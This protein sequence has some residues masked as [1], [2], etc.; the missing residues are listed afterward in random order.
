MNLKHSIPKVILEKYK[1]TEIEYSAPFNVKKSKFIDGFIIVDHNYIYTFIDNKLYKKYSLL[2]LKK[3]YTVPTFGG[4]QMLAMYKNGK[5][6][7]MLSYTKEYVSLLGSIALGIDMYV[8]ENFFAKSNQNETHCPKCHLP[9][10]NGSTTCVFCEKKIGIIRQLLK[11]IYPYRF[12]IIFQYLLLLIPIIISLFNPWIY[13]KLV[14]D[15]IYAKNYNSSFLFL[16]ISL[17]CLY[18]VSVLINIIKGRIEPVVS[19]GIVNDIRISLY[20]KVQKLSLNS[21]NSKTTG[22]LINRLSNDTSVIQSFLT[23][24]LPYIIING[25]TILFSVIIMAIMEPIFTLAIIL[26]MPLVFLIR[27]LIYVKIGSKYS[28]VWRYNEKANDTLHDIINGIKVVKTFSKEEKEINRFKKCNEDIKIITY[29]T[30]KFWY[31]LMPITWLTFS[32]VD[33][34]AFYYLGSKV[35]NMQLQYG[36]MTKW[37]AY[38]TMLY[39]GVQYFINLPRTILNFSVS[40]VKVTEILN[41]PIVESHEKLKHDIHGDIC[42]DNVRFGYLSYTPVLK[43]INFSVKSGEKIGIVGHSGSGKST[44]VNL[45]MKLYECDNGKIFIDG[46]DLKDLDQYYY[47]KQLGV[48]LQ[49]TYLFNG[50]IIENIRYG[51]SNATYEE[52]IEAAKQAHAH[53][54]IVQKELG[55][56]TKIGIRGAGLSGGEMQRIAIARAILNKPNIFILD[57]ATAS[58]DAVTESQIH[59]EL[60]DIIKNKTTFMIA[61]RLSTLRNVDRLIVLDNGKIVEIGSH[62]EL[63]KKKGFYYNLVN[64][65]YM[66][67]QKKVEEVENI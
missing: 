57:E 32:V 44:L 30:E 23:N 7:C 36:A 15:F 63:L 19:N 26:P 58:L 64:A 17:V 39:S 20:E 42:F 35:L 24:S 13:E 54:F 40:A 50:T 27:K 6:I 12:K 59:E 37:I 49:E 45:L 52:V 62:N 29:E 2:S 5:T 34:I 31:V 18:L 22:G 9:Y 10:Q 55:Y 14:D 48:V 25:L 61:H 47:R 16:I 43:N 21:A 60:Q 46:I 38:S 28:R 66:T 8:N 11:Y 67:Y 65:Q 1:F 56:D 3:V 51:N 41:E 33:V 53:D 4:G